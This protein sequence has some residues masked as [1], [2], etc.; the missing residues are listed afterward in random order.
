MLVSLATLLCSCNVTSGGIARDNMAATA[1]A[2]MAPSQ[3][4]QEL[5]RHVLEYRERHLPELI[6]YPTPPVH[7]GMISEDPVDY[8][9]ESVYREYPYLLAGQYATFGADSSITTLLEMVQRQTKSE[10]R[11]EGTIHYHHLHPAIVPVRVEDPDDLRV[12]PGRPNVGAHFLW[13]PTWLGPIMAGAHGHVSDSLGFADFRQH[14]FVDDQPLQ[15]SVEA[16]DE[17]TVLGALSMIYWRLDGTIGVSYR[18]I[19]AMVYVLLPGTKFVY[20]GAL[21]EV[22]SVNADEVKLVAHLLIDMPPFREL[23]DSAAGQANEQV[24]E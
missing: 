14:L 7:V 8:M 18:S 2:R 5:A 6:S 12:I 24:D 1:P 16:L 17:R 10:A 19:P 23:T 9:R 3:R 15:V 4:E 21:Y 13:Q 11:R 22:V 20:N